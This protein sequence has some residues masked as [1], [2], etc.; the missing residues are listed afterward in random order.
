V[1]IEKLANYLLEKHNLVIASVL[2]EKNAG[3]ICTHIWISFK[4]ID[5]L[6]KALRELRTFA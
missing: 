4:Q 5:V 3:R 6:L 2:R 1:K